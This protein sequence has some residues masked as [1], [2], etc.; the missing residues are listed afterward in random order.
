MT[1]LGIGAAI[2]DGEI[3]RGDIDI[4]DDGTLIAVGLSPAGR[5]L[6]VPA[7]VDLQV[8]GF[9]GADFTTARQ[10]QVISAFMSIAGTGVTAAMPTIITSSIPDTR[11]AIHKFSELRGR[12]H[13][14]RVLSPHLEGPF[15]APGR[16]GAHSTQHR[17]DPSSLV[18]DDLLDAGPVGLVT[19]A[20]ELD[21][22]HDLIALLLKRD[23][24]VAIGHS[25]S[26][27]LE[28][29]Q[30]FEAGA[31]ALTH[32]FNAMPP[33]AGRAPGPL[34]AALAH[35]GV[36]IMVIAD[37]IHVDSHNIQWLF[38]GFSRRMV[39]V[40]D[41]VAADTV[42]LSSPSLGGA[43]VAI[44]AGAPRLGDGTLAGSVLTL[45]EAV[46]NVVNLGVPVESAVNAATRNPA[47]TIT[48]SDLG[49]LRVGRRDDLVMLDDD[50]QVAAVFAEGNQIA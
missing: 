31:C 24:R 33:I 49:I 43:R 21:G 19:L 36:S 4:S 44:T 27:A 46:R 30:A 15:I 7:F 32:A 37:G 3:I 18:L 1:R 14:V 35:K 39:L 13:G 16:L 22:A 8:N 38:G 6:A 50:L 48:R 20:P 10:D 2:V 23:I 40:T 42:E 41:A 25:A 9:G 11:A 29:S 12:L 26:T 17:L 45:D 28:A 47:R 5:G 34:G